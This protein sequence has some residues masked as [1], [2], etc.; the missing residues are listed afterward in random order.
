MPST[1]PPLSITRT[2]SGGETWWYAYQ[3]ASW[4]LQNNDTSAVIVTGL[5]NGSSYSSLTQDTKLVAN[6]TQL[7]NYTYYINNNGADTN[8]LGGYPNQGYDSNPSHTYAGMEIT[9]PTTLPT[10]VGY[11]FTGWL[12]SDTGAVLSPTDAPFLMPSGNLTLTAQWEAIPVGIDVSETR[13]RL[14]GNFDGTTVGAEEELTITAALDTNVSKVWKIAAAS[15]AYAMPPSTYLEGV[16]STDISTDSVVYGEDLTILLSASH[17][18]STWYNT[19]VKLLSVNSDQPPVDKLFSG[20]LT[21]G[22]N[23][24]TFTFTSDVVN[25]GTSYSRIRF[26][27]DEFHMYR[28]ASD[29][30][31]SPVVVSSHTQPNDFTLTITLNFNVPADGYVKLVGY[32]GIKLC[33]G[34]LL[35]SSEAVTYATW[36]GSLSPHLSTVTGQQLTVPMT[37]ADVPLTIT[38]PK[39]AV[40]TWFSDADILPPNILLIC[41]QS[42]NLG[43][44]YTT[45][46]TVTPIGYKMTITS[47]PVGTTA[48]YIIY[49]SR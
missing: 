43:V 41:D 13:M 12:R 4:E 2:T 20:T 26:F 15:A 3:F 32:W 42:K 9:L 30:T 38:L 10:K 22:T 34:Q 28:R 40:K 44:T 17:A 18:A 39:D 45:T 27:S 6:R 46:P 37:P 16:N 11:M 36:N 21:P 48:V 19:D 33:I 24:V 35:A 23:N 25:W 47:V 14:W 5:A 7:T 49:Q 29:G 8:A 31:V 1:N